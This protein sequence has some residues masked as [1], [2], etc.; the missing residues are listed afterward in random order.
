MGGEKRKAEWIW[1]IVRWSIP[2]LLVMICLC[3]RFPRFFLQGLAVL[4]CF[5]VSYVFFCSR[6]RL[7]KSK[8]IALA[9]CVL[10]LAF[11]C[12]HG[13][14]VYGVH[15][16][17]YQIHD[18]D[19]NVFKGKRILVMVPHQDDEINLFGGLYE[20]FGKES[21]IYVMFSTNGDRKVRAETRY[22]EAVNA[23]GQMGVDRD[24]IIFLGYGDG[25][26]G[27]NGLHMYN[28]PGDE[29]FTSS[30]G[31][32]RTYA[33]LGFEPYRDSDYTR[34]NMKKDI[35]AL[36]LDLRPDVVFCVDYDSHHDHR[37]LS[38]LFEEAMGEILGREENDYV[39]AVFKGFAYSTA[40]WGA[41]DFYADNIL[42][43]VPWSEHYPY[44]GK[45]FTDRN[46]ENVIY[47]GENNIYRWR[48]RIRFPVA[49]NN[50]SRTLRAGNLYKAMHAHQ[51]QDD[52]YQ[53]FES[54]P[55]IVN[56]DKVF[57]MRPTTGLL[58]GAEVS[59]SSGDGSVLKDFKLTD[60]PDVYDK[61]RGPFENLW[62]PEETDSD[63]TAVFTFR[64]ETA[65]D[66]ICLYDNPALTDNLTRLRILFSDGSEMM[67][68]P[69]IMNG[70]GTWIRFDEKKL[71]GF[72][73]QILASEGE[74]PGLSEVEAYHAFDPAAA[75]P[76]MMKL[77]NANGDFVYDYWLTEGG[78]TFS[79]YHSREAF[80]A[81][82][83]R[84][85]SLRVTDGNGFVEKKDA[86]TFLVSCKKGQSAELT[87]YAEGRKEPVDRVTVRN[88]YGIERWWMRLLTEAE[89]K[90]DLYS[91]AEQFS[92]F[93]RTI[94]DYWSKLPF[95]S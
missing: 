1:H 4:L 52:L 19:R 12:V 13:A 88:P 57:W 31:Y 36:L 76:E 11:L 46:G 70:S 86:R 45:A 17:R 79:V 6:R 62:A 2:V 55:R 77:E 81:D 24:H 83:P 35:K 22:T 67:C 93:R 42:S 50:L 3:F 85:Y 34:D 47:M 5:P 69:L 74:K 27:E 65:V 60:S 48:D 33:A 90:A 9:V 75:V 66:A 58:Y 18:L 71:T 16:A 87:L 91:P 56:G 44:P 49:E 43:A 61:T 7:L 37:A 25:C 78:E 8:G 30:P 54:I 59:V 28:L 94:L 21:E 89:K 38:L 32:T 39:P 92:Y 95:V 15:N 51:S 29:V 64:Q 14:V 40:F 10:L 68:G 20:T 84:E 72:T 26:Y 23:L 82:V 41:D 63:R 80:Q 73:V 53:A